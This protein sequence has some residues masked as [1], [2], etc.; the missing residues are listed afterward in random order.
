MKTIAKTLVIILAT[1]SNIQL[2]AQTEHVV[3]VSADKANVFYIGIDNPLSVSVPGIANDKLRVTSKNGSLTGSNGKYTV[4][5]DNTADVMI[6]V[7]AEIKPGA[8][9]D[10]GET[11]FRVKRIP[12]PQPCIADKCGAIVS[13]S[14]HELLQNPRISIMVN[15]PFELKFEVVSFTMSSMLNG[16]LKTESAS[17]NKFTQQMT[18]MIKGM[19]AGGK[20]NIENIKVKGPDGT[21]RMLNAK[22]IILI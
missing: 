7:T 4:K 5:V 16:N 19:E 3:I 18:D 13:I 12:D 9:K 17:G 8:V 11:T 6:H 15:L 14:K 20:L 10:Y 22:T 1:L 21:T 2:F